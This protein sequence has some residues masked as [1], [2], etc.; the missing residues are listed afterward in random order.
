[1]L[2]CIESIG[3]LVE[4]SITGDSLELSQAQCTILC[5]SVSRYQSDATIIVPILKCVD[6][7]AMNDANRQTLI[8]ISPL[9]PSILSAHLDNAKVV[10]GACLVIDHLCYDNETNCQRLMSVQLY[11]LLFQRT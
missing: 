2:L 4:N 7:S 8:D 10:E 5:L 9:M 6:I 1:M 11:H 3:E